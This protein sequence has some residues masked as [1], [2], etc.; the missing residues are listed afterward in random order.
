MKII[1]TVQL[2]LILLSRFFTSVF[3]FIRFIYH[4]QVRL[5]F[6]I[7]LDDDFLMILL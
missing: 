7:M 6:G 2:S 5:I 1:L 4:F 3:I